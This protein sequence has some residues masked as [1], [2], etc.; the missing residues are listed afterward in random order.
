MIQEQIKAETLVASQDTNRFVQQRD[1]SLIRRAED[2][3]NWHMPALELMKK[4]PTLNSSTQTDPSL[5]ICLAAAQRNLGEIDQATK[6]MQKLVS[7]LPKGRSELRAL[8]G[9]DPWKDI[10]LSE[11]WLMNRA[12]GLGNPKLVGV[13]RRAAARPKLDGIFD[14]E[15]WK[16][17][18]PLKLKPVQAQGISS[19]CATLRVRFDSDFL[20]LAMECPHDEGK[21]IPKLSRRTR[22]M[23]LQGQDRVALFFD[24]DRDYQT[25]FRFEFDARGAVRDDCWG[26]ST[27]NPK[28]FVAMN[29]DESHWRAEI[30]IPLVELTNDSSLPGKIWAF[31][32]IR[33]KKSGEKEA[34]SLRNGKEPELVDLGLLQFLEQPQPK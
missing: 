11:L 17:V 32:V 33:T 8:K 4:F 10:L 30:A 19:G 9:V 18:V 23:N 22:D 12:D 2:N 24:L 28:W 29:S 26:D 6:Y 13:A 31:N 25:F 3:R 14:D 7:E 5:E 27:W 15:C 1:V 34:W 16:D 20:Y 21:P